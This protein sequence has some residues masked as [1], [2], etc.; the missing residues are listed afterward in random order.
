MKNQVQLYRNLIHIY[1]PDA[2]RY[3]HR[4]HSAHFQYPI[5]KKNCSALYRM[6]LI[7]KYLLYRWSP[8]SQAC[9]ERCISIQFW[10]LIIG[11]LAACPTIESAHRCAFL[12]TYSKTQRSA[13]WNYPIYSKMFFTEIPISI[14]FDKWQFHAARHSCSFSFL[15]NLLFASARSV[16]SRIY[17]ICA[18]L[19]FQLIFCLS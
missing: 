4:T 11:C 8:L 18:F 9:V 19:T 12:S 5:F 6:I 1:I 7:K 14:S 17:S 3:N 16:S 10:F 2:I 15:W 13:W